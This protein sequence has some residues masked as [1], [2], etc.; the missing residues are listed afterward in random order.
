MRRKKGKLKQSTMKNRLPGH[1]K[2]DF[3]FRVSAGTLGGL[4][5]A[6]PM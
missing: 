5:S 3:M 4:F 2:K 6:I 1:R